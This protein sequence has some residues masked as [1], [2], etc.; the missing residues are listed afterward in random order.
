MKKLILAALVSGSFSAAYAQPS[1]LLYGMG[2]YS[3]SRST[4]TNKIGSVTTTSEDRLISY[5]IAPGIGINLSEHLAVGIEI[6]YQG[7]KFNPDTSFGGSGAY[8]IKNRDLGV[9]PFVRY[10]RPVGEHFFVYGQFTARYL[11]GRNTEYFKTGSTS[12]SQEDRYSGFNAD[13]YPAFGIRVTRSCAL[14]FGFGGLGY[15]YRKYDFFVPAGAP[16]GT[17]STGKTNN[18]Q[19]TFGQQFNVGVQKTFGGRQRAKGHR[20]P[21]DDTR[22]LNGSDEDESSKKKSRHDDDE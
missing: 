20:Q 13:L 10:T 12:T 9:G 5:T 16:A 22:D 1:I 17:E 8:E 7:S 6:S 4:Q 18:F 11:N 14:T 21:M 15:D 19:V 2:E 3:S